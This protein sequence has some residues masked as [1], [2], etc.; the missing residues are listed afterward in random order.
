MGQGL[1]GGGHVRQSVPVM[2]RRLRVR[3]GVADALGLGRIQ[4]DDAPNEAANPSAA[5]PV[6]AFVQGDAPES[7][8]ERSGRIIA[9]DR[10]PGRSV[11]L[12]DQIQRLVGVADIAT[13]EPHQ[14]ALAR[15]HQG[16]EGGSLA[17]SGSVLEIQPRHG[18]V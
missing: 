11:G 18:S 7:D 1:Q 13:H 16:A 15:G 5:A 2:K 3:G 8:V 6:A 9:T 17:G 12:L 4:A 10:Q 14:V